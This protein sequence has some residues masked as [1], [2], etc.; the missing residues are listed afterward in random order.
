MG[1]RLI[2]V[3]LISV[4]FTGIA[5]P[6]IHAGFRAISW[7][8]HDKS[9]GCCLLLLALFEMPKTAH[10]CSGIAIPS[11]CRYPPQSVSRLG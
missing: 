6:S 4:H 2:G 1:K 8:Y 3:P 7:N 10:S 5:A 9:I 11:H